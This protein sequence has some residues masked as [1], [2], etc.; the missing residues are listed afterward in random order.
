M[1]RS[2]NINQIIILL[3]IHSGWILAGTSNQARDIDALLEWG[4][5]RR[6]RNPSSPWDTTL[7]GAS[8][9]SDIVSLFSIPQREKPMALDYS[10]LNTAAERLRLANEV[11]NDLVGMIEVIANGDLIRC[12]DG[13][14]RWVADKQEFQESLDRVLVM[15]LS[16][17]LQTGKESNY[18]EAYDHLCKICPKISQRTK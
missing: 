13:D 16:G 6:Q 15:V 8:K 2:L 14:Q 10:I 18:V 9:V 17:N 3:K 5:I 1:I 7:E 11:C 4:L 12:D